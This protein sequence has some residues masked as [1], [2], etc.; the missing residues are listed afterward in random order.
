MTWSWSHTQEAYD[1]ARINLMAITDEEWIDECW[2]EWQAHKP[3]AE[4]ADFEGFS[5]EAVEEADRTKEQVDSNDKKEYIWDQAS[6]L[7]DCT[8]GGWL[9]HMC[10]YGCHTV[11]FSPPEYKHADDV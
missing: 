6:E 8:N 5:Q 1:Q 4:D 10:P 3:D 11:S 2:L 9:A 7:R